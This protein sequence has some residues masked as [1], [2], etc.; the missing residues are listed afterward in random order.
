MSESV[1]RKNITTETIQAVFEEIDTDRDGR[2]TM[3]EYAQFLERSGGISPEKLDDFSLASM[4]G[5]INDLDFV[6]LVEQWVE[7]H[8]IGDP[9][10]RLLEEM[11]RQA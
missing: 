2:I 9:A 10:V 6:Q 1:D 8:D 4:D 7:S 5:E 11:F 3:Q